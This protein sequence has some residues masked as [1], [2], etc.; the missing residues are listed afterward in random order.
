[1]RTSTPMVWLATSILAFTAGCSGFAPQCSTDADCAVTSYCNPDALAC[2]GRS[3]G[4]VV[5]VLDAVS[6]GPGAGTITVAGTAQATWTVNIFTNATCS[7][8][9]A[10]SGTADSSGN[11]SIPAMAPATGTAFANAESAS[12]GALCSLGKTYP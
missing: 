5:P 10:G 12:G 4:A 7:G 1:M 9:A 11:F 2:F 8:A 6:V 3:A